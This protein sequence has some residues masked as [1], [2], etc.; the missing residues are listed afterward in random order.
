[1]KG[2]RIMSECVREMTFE[3]EAEKFIKWYNE[4]YSHLNI[5]NND[6]NPEYLNLLRNANRTIKKALRESRC[7]TKSE[8]SRVISNEEYFRI[9]NENEYLKETIIKLIVEKY[10]NY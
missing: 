1:M 2:E 9:K 6:N 3:E 10:C 4:F 7:E 5:N 8:C